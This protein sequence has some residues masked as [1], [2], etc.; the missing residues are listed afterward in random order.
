MLFFPPRKSITH[1][2]EI[3]WE[4]TVAKAAPCTPILNTKMKSG[5][6]I[7]LEIAPIT[8]VSIPIFAK[9]WAVIYAFIPRVS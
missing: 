3:A 1:T 4:I 2:Q 7:I 6:R 9:P 8:T 5:S